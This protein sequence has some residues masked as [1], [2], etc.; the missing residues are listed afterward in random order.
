MAAALFCCR[1]EGKQR[2]YPFG[3][4][5]VRLLRGNGLAAQLVMPTDTLRFYLVC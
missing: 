2:F 4:I 5:F 3:A 1:R